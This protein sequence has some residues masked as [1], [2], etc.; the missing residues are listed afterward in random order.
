LHHGLEIDRTSCP[1]SGPTS[2]AFCLPPPPTPDAGNQTARQ[3]HTLARAQVST[4]RERLFKLSARIEES[5]RRIVVPCLKPFLTPRMALHRP[6]TWRRTWLIT[7]THSLT[8]MRPQ[9][10]QLWA[11]PSHK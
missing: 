5:V 1:A 11:H 6:P 7:T 4:L 2:F 8:D 3:T 10:H 9:P